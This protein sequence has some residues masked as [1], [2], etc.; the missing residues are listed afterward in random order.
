MNTKYLCTDCGKDY[1]IT[2]DLMVC[3]ECS[4][5]QNDNEPLKGILEVDYQNR[6]LKENW[7][8]FDMLPVPEEY[9]PQIPV[10]NTPMWK[11][12]N[13]RKQLELPNLF[14]K[15]DGAN[16]TASL[17]DRASWLVSAFAKQNCIDNIVLASTGNAGSSMAGIGA[18]A[19]QRV[20]LFL[21][22]AAPVAKL[23]Q[24]QQYGADLVL[25]DG[26]YD[27]AFA[28]AM[29]YCKKFGGMNRNTAFNPMTIEGKKTVSIEMF[30]QLNHCPDHVFVSCGDGC[31]LSGVYKGFKDLYMAGLIERVPKIWAIQSE[32]SNT[33][34]RAFNHPEHQFEF[35][36]ATTLAD[37]ISVDMPASGYHALKQLKEFGGQCVT[38]TDEQILE[39]QKLLAETTGLFAEPAGATAFA[40]LLAVRPHLDEQDTVVVLT[41]GHGLKDPKTA[42]Q[43]CKPLPAPISSLSQLAIDR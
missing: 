19:G 43:G 34:T 6:D 33:L 10:G 21:P 23:I 22:V 8:V 28:M 31:I 3:P 18:A 17:K 7:S 20:T 27:Q 15:D 1:P 40:G 38:V 41:T 29:D 37:S 9:F 12:A 14:I 25:V 13:L 24:S 42:A 2:P 4:A 26:N 30:R 16:P 32:N 39:S 36:A 35:Q 11:P 5:N